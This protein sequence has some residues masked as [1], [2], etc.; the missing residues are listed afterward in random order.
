MLPIKN[1]DFDFK[2]SLFIKNI[3]K[4]WT[5]SDLHDYFRQYG[6]VKSAKVALYSDHK[7]KGFGYI[8]YSMQSYAEQA[9]KHS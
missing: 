2:N 8:H 7:S 4:A 6:S 3:P 5:S 1:E 9:I